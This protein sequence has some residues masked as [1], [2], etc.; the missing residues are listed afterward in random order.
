[1]TSHQ[2]SSDCK[3]FGV[4]LSLSGCVLTAAA[5]TVAAQKLAVTVAARGLVDNLMAAAMEG[6][7]AQKLAVAACSLVDNLTAGATEADPG[8]AVR[9]HTVEPSCL[10]VVGCVSGGKS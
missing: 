7:V 10:T 4:A 5:S 6:A 8:A 1:V 9:C 2:S 3:A